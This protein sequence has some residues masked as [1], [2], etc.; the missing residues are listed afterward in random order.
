MS[1]Q[2]IVKED[3]FYQLGDSNL[4]QKEDTSKDSVFTNKQEFSS[5]NVSLMYTQQEKKGYTSGRL[6]ISLI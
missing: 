4:S 6:R 5:G 3:Y 2:F 1:E